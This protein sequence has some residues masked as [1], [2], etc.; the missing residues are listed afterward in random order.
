MAAALVITKEQP[1]GRTWKEGTLRE[2]VPPEHSRRRV[3]AE[4]VAGELSRLLLM[5]L[6]RTRPLEGSILS[7]PSRLLSLE[8]PNMRISLGPQPPVA[9]VDRLVRPV[10]LT[11]RMPVVC[12]KVA[13]EDSA[14]KREG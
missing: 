12:L 14:E 11:S 3:R 7:R 1:P 6:M 9:K 2:V 4:K 10:L 8:L 5:M 13:K